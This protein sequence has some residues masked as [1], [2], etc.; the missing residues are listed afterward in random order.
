MAQF[1]DAAGS[2]GGFMP[3]TLQEPYSIIKLL[4]DVEMLI[5]SKVFLLI[6]ESRIM[7]TDIRNILSRY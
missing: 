3:L 7:C 5:R 4:R 6:Y 1:N 2:V